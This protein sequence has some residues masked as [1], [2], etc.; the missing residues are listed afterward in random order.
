[1]AI[2]SLSCSIVVQNTRSVLFLDLGEEE[3]SSYLPPL[4]PLLRSNTIANMQ[5]ALKKA[6]AED[7]AG[8]PSG[9]FKSSSK[10][11]HN[12]EKA[13]LAKLETKQER[14]EM[15][16]QLA[17]RKKSVKVELKKVKHS[18]R[19]ALL[20]EALQ[21]RWSKV[22]ERTED[23]VAK[24][25]IQQN[26]TM[27]ETLEREV[28]LLK[29]K[30]ECKVTEHDLLCKKGHKGIISEAVRQCKVLKIKHKHSTLKRK[31]SAIQSTVSTLKDEVSATANISLNTNDAPVVE[32]FKAD[33]RDISSKQLAEKECLLKFQERCEKQASKHAT[34]CEEGKSQI[35]KDNESTYSS[36]FEDDV[37]EENECSKSDQEDQPSSPRY[38]LYRCMRLVPLHKLLPRPLEIIDEE[39]SEDLMDYEKGMYLCNIK[40]YQSCNE[41]KISDCSFED[42]YYV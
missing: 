24:A 15:K 39:T 4:R 35:P 21:A 19:R 41:P 28:E 18:K 20:E 13:K 7:N 42:C 8:V 9:F 6:E 34:D 38:P 29:E 10:K 1:M 30:Q 3:I 14:Q 17:Q 33:L 37:D 22:D 2:A 23:E 32:S 26:N 16:T 5:E 12:T 25:K 27:I 36:D 11:Q 31:I 40:F